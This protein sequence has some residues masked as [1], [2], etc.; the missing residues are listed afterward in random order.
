MLARPADVA[1]DAGVRSAVSRMPRTQRCQTRSL[2]VTSVRL[3]G[4]AAI[5]PVNLTKRPR[6]WPGRVIVIDRVFG[7]CD[8]R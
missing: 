5:N 2:Q 1:S 6:F 3:P 8:D 7:D 4:M